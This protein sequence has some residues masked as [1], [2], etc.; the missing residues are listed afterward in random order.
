MRK[1]GDQE[2]IDESQFTDVRELRAL[3]IPQRLILT[4]HVSV[5]SSI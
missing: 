4:S 3:T 1:G 5:A 2:D